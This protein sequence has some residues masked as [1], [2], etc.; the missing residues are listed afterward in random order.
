LGGQSCYGIAK[1]FWM[2]PPWNDCRIS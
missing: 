1:E 2:G